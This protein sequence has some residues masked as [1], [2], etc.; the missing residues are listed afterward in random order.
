MPPAYVVHFEIPVADLDRATTFYEA[1]FDLALERRDVDGYTM[2]FFPRGDGHPGTAG[3]LAAG[4]VYVPG[5]QGPILYFDVPD[6][7]AVL[8]RAQALGAPVLYPKTAIGPLG[9]VA[10]FGD[11]EGN[12]IALTQA[13]N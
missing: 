8:D 11:S 6:I 2:A 12:R 13:P 1:V 4:D 7:D 10:E 5:R 9:Y 3:A